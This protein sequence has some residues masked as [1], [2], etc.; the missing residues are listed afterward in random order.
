[1]SFK[2]QGLKTSGLVVMATAL[3]STAVLAGLSL[4][5]VSRVGV[6]GSRYREIAQRKDF[7]ADILPPPAAILE[8]YLNVHELLRTADPLA[9]Q[10][11]V[12]RGARLKL[13]FDERHR[14]W[15]DRRDLPAERFELLATSQRAARTFFDARDQRFVPAVLAGRLE[16]A[17]RLLNLE[18]RPAYEQHRESIDRL[19]RM[20]SDEVSHLEREAASSLKWTRGLIVFCALLV[21]FLVVGGVYRLMGGM[22]AGITQVVTGLRRIAAK[23]LKVEMDE[24]VPGEIGELH[25]SINEVA[26]SMRSALETIAQQAAVLTTAAQELNRVSQKLSA[27]AEE[28]AAQANVV[29]GTS[30]LVA[31]SVSLVATSTE[32]MNS[33]IREIARNA[34][35]AAQVAAEAVRIAASRPTPP[36]P[37]WASRAPRSARSSR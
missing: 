37:S 34:S 16:E 27:N 5:S 30:S 9:R 12:E 7:V 10:M 2:R 1:M 26:H 20:T 22:S 31:R 33:S 23:D 15:R 8:A 6:T 25:R 3:V 11:M 4:V 35:E 29:S 19:A 18:L 24:V 21:A 17:V 28:T 32:Q 36:W 13:D 14:I